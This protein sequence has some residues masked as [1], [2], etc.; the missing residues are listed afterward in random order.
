MH[1]GAGKATVRGGYFLAWWPT[2]AVILRITGYEE[3][4]K[5]LRP[6]WHARATRPDGC[7]NASSQS[8]HLADRGNKLRVSPYVTGP[9]VTWADAALAA[10]LLLR[11]TQPSGQG[12]TPPRGRSI[13]NM[14]TAG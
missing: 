13:P 14:R 9:Q 5:A 7:A 4:G 1:G 2:D 11:R 6:F 8:D 10:K 12:S 3:E